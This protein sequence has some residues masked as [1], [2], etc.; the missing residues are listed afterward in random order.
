MQILF[1]LHNMLEAV[2]L[3]DALLRL[4]VAVRLALLLEGFK[5]PWTAAAV[6][7]QVSSPHSSFAYKVHQCHHKDL[8]TPSWRAHITHEKPS[9][10]RKH[11]LC[12]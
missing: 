3:D 10:H 2:D 8:C 5:D 11:H 4:G 9:A 7:R 6:L 1:C 12:L